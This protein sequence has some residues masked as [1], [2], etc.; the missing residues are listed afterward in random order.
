[1]ADIVMWICFTGALSPPSGEPLVKVKE[2]LTMDSGREI[3]YDH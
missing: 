1:M 3:H 2:M